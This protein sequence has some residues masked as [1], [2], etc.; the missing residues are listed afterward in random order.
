MALSLEDV[1]FVYSKGTAFA[2]RA[3][4]GLDLSVEPG[5]TLVVLGPTGSGKSTMLRVASGLLQ[6][7]SGR[8]EVDGERDV[9]R[10]RVGLVFQDP[11][12]QLF[13][14]NVLDD[15]A[16]GPRNLGLSEEEARRAAAE[17]LLGVGLDPEDIGSRSPLTLS[18]GEARRVAVAGVLA[19]RPRYLLLDEPSSGLDA[20]GRARVHDVVGGMRAGHGVIVVTHDAEEFLPVA[21]RVLVLSEGR[22]AFLGGVAGLMERACEVFETAGLLPPDVVRAQLLADLRGARL[23]TP[24]LDPDEAAERL[25]AAAEGG[26]R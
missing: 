4:E 16:F 7:T 19:M 25:A 12:A 6:P 13:A 22:V 24:V 23:P 11:E 26:R 21:D 1:G 9:P 17:A 15:V 8:V 2:Q 5:E 14:D 18:G 20:D 10:G 3:L